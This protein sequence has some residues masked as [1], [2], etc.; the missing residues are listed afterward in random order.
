MIK[1]KV[2]S[3]DDKDYN[4]IKL[5]GQGS[6]GKVYE[7]DNDGIRY[8]VKCMDIRRPDTMMETT[9]IKTCYH[10]SIVRPYSID[11]VRDNL[12]ILMPIGEHILHSNIDPREAISN[13][14]SAIL[15][16]SDN[17][18][19]HRDIKPD[20]IIVSDG[21][22]MFIDFGM[23]TYLPPPYNRIVT[24]LGYRCPYLFINDKVYDNRIDI[25]SM[26]VVAYNILTKDYKL[27]SWRNTSRYLSDLISR[28][29]DG[30]RW[31]NENKDIL[32]S[33][34]IR[35]NHNSEKIDERMR[36]KGLDEDQISMI[37]SMLSL[38]YERIPTAQQV[39]DMEYLRPVPVH[40]GM[41]PY[42]IESEDRYPIT[43]GIEHKIIDTIA[44]D[45]PIERDIL[46]HI[47][48]LFD[49]SVL[50]NTAPSID[51]IGACYYILLNITDRQRYLDIILSMYSRKVEVLSVSLY[52]S[53]G[54][55]LYTKN[56]V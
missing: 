30:I 36:R 29:P 37:M 24:S 45:I 5:L 48:S 54:Y 50:R 1:M 10:P 44:D 23:G 34:N 42:I 26:G 25:W 22:A 56:E 51:L 19:M 52:I 38:D 43:D 28:H 15:Y 4:V 8:A 17:D 31:Y 11:N 46:Y 35:I 12:Y 49:I 40:H 21:K 16:M 32:S 2:F 33:Y 13:L 6:Y 47:H 39:L 41:T 18:I 53:L 3:I 55:N 7:V 20:N 14:V 9:L 27:F